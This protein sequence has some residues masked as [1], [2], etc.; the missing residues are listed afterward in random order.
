MRADEVERLLGTLAADTAAAGRRDHAIVAFLAGTGARLGSALALD[1]EELD[2][3]AGTATLR[4][5]KG[6]SMTVFLRPELVE[7]LAAWIGDRDGGSVFAARNGEALTAQQAQRRFEHWLRVAGIRGRFSPH[8]LRHT[9]ALGLY[10][11]TGD[12]PVVKEA[13][14]HRALSS[15][16]VYARA[17]AERVRAAVVG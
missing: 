17:S 6:G 4:E 12:V 11:R 8:S 3:A 2:L 5:M 13:L 16:M 9:F 15:T 1:V 10:Q 14:G 7:R